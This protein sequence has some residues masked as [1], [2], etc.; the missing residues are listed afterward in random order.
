MDTKD[1]FFV[2]PGMDVRIK[3]C[4]LFPGAK[5]IILNVTPDKD[6][7]FAEPGTT[8][9]VSINAGYFPYEYELHQL[10]ADPQPC[11]PL[12]SPNLKHGPYTQEEFLTNHIACGD[13][14]MVYGYFYQ[15]E[16]FTN[17]SYAVSGTSIFFPSEERNFR[18]L[19]LCHSRDEAVRIL[20]DLGLYGQVQ[21]VTGNIH[22]LKGEPVKA[23]V[24]RNEY[25]WHAPYPDLTAGITD[26]VCVKRPLEGEE[27][28]VHRSLFGEM[29]D[30]KVHFRS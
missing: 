18:R 8:V 25:W 9:K 5:G 4:P 29:D 10:A 19:P 27:A 26:Y 30:V 20:Q 21:R 17:P 6:G 14:G 3:Q 11:C 15:P 22:L 2:Y 7:F 23:V 16:R 1:R 24:G 13:C 28:F 12:D